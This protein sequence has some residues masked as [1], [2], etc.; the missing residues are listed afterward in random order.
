MVAR[1]LEKDEWAKYLS[2]FEHAFYEE[3]E[4]ENLANFDRFRST[5]KLEKN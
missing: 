1:N 5:L 3:N 2:G 4:A